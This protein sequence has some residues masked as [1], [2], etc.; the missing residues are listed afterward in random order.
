VHLRR[1]CAPRF[2][3]H[4]QVNRFGEV[5]LLDSEERFSTRTWYGAISL[6]GM[7]D[8]LLSESK[9][10][11]QALAAS[12]WPSVI[13]VLEGCPDLV[14]AVFP[15]NRRQSTLLH[16]AAAGEVSAYFV[17]QLLRL[18]AFRTVRD[19]SG[20][21]AVEIVERTGADH[22]LTLLKPEIN[23]NLEPE[24]ISFIQ[25]M[26]HGFLRTFMLAYKTPVPLRLPQLSVFTEVDQLRVWFPIP[27]MAGGCSFWIEEEK[28]QS[29]LHAETWCR[30]C[31]GSGMHHRITPFEITLL[32][33]GFV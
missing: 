6:K 10:I 4:A 1:N 15:K 17:E 20:L 9:A 33:E 28:S 32:E 14:N 8:H 2:C 12:D 29:V 25:E 5:V 19:A 30:I 3:L 26:F 22:L 27:M 7:N 18:G 11:D 21:Q 16:M 23:R 31:S 13:Q 24:R